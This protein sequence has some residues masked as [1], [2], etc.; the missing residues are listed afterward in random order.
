MTV[1]CVGDRGYSAQETCYI[2]A[3]VTVATNVQAGFTR[4]AVTSC[5]VL[6]LDGSRAVEERVQQGGQATALSIVDHQTIHWATIQ[7]QHHLST[8]TPCPAVHHI[9]GGTG[10]TCSA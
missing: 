9:Q 2:L 5:I 1:A 3:T 6:S 7:G 4:H 10:C 8:S